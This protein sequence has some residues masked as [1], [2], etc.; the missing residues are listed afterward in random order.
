MK[1]VSLLAAF[2]VVRAAAFWFNP[3]N[4]Y[5]ATPILRQPRLAPPHYV[6][7][8]PG[9][10]NAT[11]WKAVIDSTW[12]P[13][14][15]ASEKEDTWLN[16][17][18]TIETQYAGFH[19]YPVD[20]DSVGD[21]YSTT[22]V[23]YDTISRGRFAGI[24]AH[25]SRALHDAHTRTYDFDV[26]QTA[27]LPGVPLLVRGG[28]RSA[29]HFGAAL[30]LVPDSSLL[31]YDVIDSH[32]LGLVPG[33]LVLGYDGIPWKDLYPELIA[34][35]L[36]LAEPSA[37][38]W[39]G[40]ESSYPHSWLMAAGENWHLFDTIDIVKYASG[41]TLHLPTS[42]LLGVQSDLVIS[43]QLPVPGVL[44]PASYATNAVSW[45]SWKALGSDTSMS[46]AGFPERTPCG[47]T[48]CPR[49]CSIR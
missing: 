17:W 24:M 43:D 22:N 36:P 6:Q 1:Q 23:D 9:H 35:Q 18:L 45:G 30:T 47:S 33:D 46:G 41:D 10:Y 7:K 16:F 14:M 40:T 21:L 27:L 11:D 19:N 26:S 37:P 32:P 8:R 39:S 25:A 12:G 29:G 38:W 48:L 49:S 15:P 42:L 34:A 20:W 31:V 28:W 13:G 5:G 4:L 3:V 2:G 44:K